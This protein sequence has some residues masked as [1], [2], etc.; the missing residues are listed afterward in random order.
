[1]CEIIG[2]GE[3]PSRSPAKVI[4]IVPQPETVVLSA[5][6]LG[7]KIWT[8]TKCW[9]H[10]KFMNC[11]QVER[12]N[13]IIK[14]TVLKVPGDE[15]GWHP[16]ASPRVLC[17]IKWQLAG[18]SLPQ[19]ERCHRLQALTASN[20][21]SSGWGPWL[22][23]AH[24]LPAL[25]SQHSQGTVT[26]QMKAGHR[27]LPPLS[28]LPT[29]HHLPSEET[30]GFI[31]SSYCLS[32]VHSC[33]SWLIVSFWANCFYLCYSP[34]SS[35]WPPA[36]NW[37]AMGAAGITS[38]G[39]IY[40][41][42]VLPEMKPCVVPFLKPRSAQHVGRSLCHPAFASVFLSGLISRRIHTTVKNWCPTE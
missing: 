40:V 27:C 22:H 2:T 37:P 25:G 14:Q 8:N 24:K 34:V 13:H 11:R 5:L 39:Y 41:R 32:V 15:F 18:H 30:C 42:D 17:T 21:P 31:I 12:V 4:L 9:K 35:T 10:W 28:G 7:G 1:M 19:P 33:P 20:R 3:S 36:M 16:V 38:P 6:P 26:Q 23:L 29:T